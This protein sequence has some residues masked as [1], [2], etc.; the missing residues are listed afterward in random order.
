MLSQEWR[1]VPVGPDASRWVTRSG[2]RTVLAVVH[3]VTSGQRMLDI[4]RLFENDL[5][6]QVVFTMAPD[7][8]SNGV[9]QFLEEL[10]A[11]TVPWQQATNTS[12]DLAVTASYGAVH[13]LQ[14]P[15]VIV[16]H[17]AG[18]NKLA[19]RRTQR[20]TIA[21]RAVYGLEPQRLIQ[22]GSVIPAALILSHRDDL[23]RLGRTCPE[24]LP[25]AVVAGDPCH[26]RIVAS[27]PRRNAYRRALGIEDDEK[28]ILLTS[29]WGKGSLFGDDHTLLTR[30]VTTLPPGHRVL[31]LIHPNAWFAH[32]GWQ[33]RAWLADLC[34]NGLALMP[35]EADWRTALVAADWIIGD[36]GSVALYGTAAQVPV[37]LAQF[38]SGEVD[39]DSAAALLAA[40]APHL[41]RRRSLIN[42]LRE[43]TQTHAAGG[44]EPVAARITSEPGRFDRNMRRLLYRMLKLKQPARISSTEPAPPPF[45][46]QGR[47]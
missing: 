36:H 30:L 27:L 6:I 34:R 40:T 19:S 17:G 16:P 39:P 25:S 5:R 11:V 45:L 13:E 23:E 29:T 18:Y 32:G 44:Y 47:K 2:C 42:Q 26:D 31:S 8:F 28:L 20:A 4:V 33:I 12:F 7:V 41:R 22:D 10:G 35:P 9:A 1:Q 21:N 37:L 43:A 46:I 24:A 15:L 3:T 38:P 14:A